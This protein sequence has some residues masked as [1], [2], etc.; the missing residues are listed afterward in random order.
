IVRRGANPRCG[1]EIEVGLY[2]QDGHL[3]KVKFRG[4]GCSVCIASSSMMTEAVQGHSTSEARQLC[5]DMQAWFEKGEGFELAEPPESLQ[6]LSAVRAYPARRR[7]VLLSWEA[8][9]EALDSI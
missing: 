4:R 1:D 5:F 2:L 7:C 3:A 6:A 9:D 8:L